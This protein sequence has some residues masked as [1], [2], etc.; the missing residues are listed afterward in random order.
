MKFYS[1]RARFPTHASQ[2]SLCR[3]F[4]FRMSWDGKSPGQ[5]RAIVPDSANQ[6]AW[7]A[8]NAKPGGRSVCAEGETSMGA[9]SYREFET[10]FNGHRN[11]M[12][13]SGVFSFALIRG[14]SEL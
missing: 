6:L 9:F 1:S 2:N 13:Q 3:S 8:Q 5:T 7:H 14:Q 4:S 12:A 11:R 10:R